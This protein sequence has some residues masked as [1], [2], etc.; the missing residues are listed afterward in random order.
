MNSPDSSPVMKRHEPYTIRPAEAP[1]LDRLV[2]LLLALQDHVEA[3]NPD[4]WRMKPE[5]RRHIKGQLAG[6]LKANSACAFVAEHDEDGVVGVI[7][8]RIVANKRY[9]PS[10]AGQVDQV[11]VRADHRRAGVGSRLVDE[12]CRFFADEEVEDM[13]LRYVLG[14]EEAASFWST[15][16]F[17]PRIITA[18]AQRQV[19]ETRLARPPHP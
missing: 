12:L 18:G 15:L 11:F 19:V 2:E 6:R 16:G 17:S 4:L 14:N 7:F 13:S 9:T 10:R 8:G 3:S 5:A 1:D